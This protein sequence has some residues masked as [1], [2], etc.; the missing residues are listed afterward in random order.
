MT[1][2]VSNFAMLGTAFHLADGVPAVDPGDVGSEWDTISFFVAGDNDPPE[3][4]QLLAPADGAELDTETPSLVVANAIDPEGDLVFYEFVVARDAELTDGVTGRTDVVEGSGAEG[5]TT[6][7]SWQVDINLAGDLYWSARAVDEDGAASDWAAPFAFHA[8]EPVLGD[9][10][11]AS[12]VGVGC[13]CESS[14]AAGSPG[15]LAW[16]LA[17]VL[18]AGVT[19]RRR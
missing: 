5:D 18:G 11:P 17:L 13:D 8:P 10:D 14:L 3:V 15:S 7:T 1:A 16:L 6:Q 19:R 2:I 12:D 9:D 4:P